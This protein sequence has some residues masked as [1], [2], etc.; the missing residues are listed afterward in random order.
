[1]TKQDAIRLITTAQ[2]V[3]ELREVLLAMVEKLAWQIE[4]ESGEHRFADRPAHRAK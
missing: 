1:M 4:I 3:D 2:S